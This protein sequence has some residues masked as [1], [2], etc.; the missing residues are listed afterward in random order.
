MKPSALVHKFANAVFQI[1]LNTSE[2]VEVATSQLL[3]RCGIIYTMWVYQAVVGIYIYWV[4]SIRDILY[5]QCIG[6][7]SYTSALAFMIYKCPEFW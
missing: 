6:Q 7:A 2:C 3:I 5:L 1:K 4:Y